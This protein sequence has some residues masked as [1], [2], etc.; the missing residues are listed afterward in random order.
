MSS[1]PRTD[2]DA[3]LVTPE[4]PV[5]HPDRRAPRRPARRSDS[6]RPATPRSGTRRSVERRPYPTAPTTT[7]ISPAKPTTRTGRAR[8]HGPSSTPTPATVWTAGPAPID[9][10]ATWPTP[11]I[12][13]I[14]TSFSAPGARV[15]L[16][17]WP[18]VDPVTRDTPTP[19]QAHAAEAIDH[20]T[21]TESED[22]VTA[23]LA[24]IEDL[25]RTGHVIRIPADP[26]TAGPTTHP[27]WT[28]LVGD[29]HRSPAASEQPS[30]S[31][32]GE[33][34]D[35]ATDFDLA[36]TSLRPE[37]RSDAVSDLVALYAAR[38]LRS[39]GVLALLT[40]CD[41]TRGELIDPSGTIVAA[42]QNADLLYLQH[43]VAL[44]VPVAN[45]HL[46]T[47]TEGP[48]AAA[49]HALAEHRA[50]V[51]RLPAPHR[52][53]HSD[54]LVFVSAQLGPSGRT[55]AAGAVR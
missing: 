49:E 15:L 44:H 51:R 19:T 12:T 21:G 11:I 9:L 3:H 50:A 20:A 27:S 41:W 29:P 5:T 40:R 55:C 47:D 31:S 18:T 22:E 25:D 39:G 23:A 7:R 28:E 2:A 43:I 33:I 24:A 54:V 8:S 14:V 26:T 46:V 10:D 53:V 35:S 32:G 37:Q 42:G 48:T 34:L 30:R 52:R 45:G 36:I 38:R 13:K 6:T 17:P 4:V 16:L 1:A